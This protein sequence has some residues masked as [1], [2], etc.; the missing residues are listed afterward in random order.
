M[1]ALD[2]SIRIQKIHTNVYQKIDPVIHYLNSLVVFLRSP[3]RF[4]M[5]Q[6]FRPVT[7][8]LAY[9]L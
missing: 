8:N 5:R 2:I 9:E 7:L 1:T 3:N 4:A 6:A